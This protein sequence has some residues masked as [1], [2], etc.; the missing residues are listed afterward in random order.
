MNRIIRVDRL[1]TRENRGPRKLK[2]NVFDDDR[3][4]EKVI[5]W[6]ASIIYLKQMKRIMTDRFR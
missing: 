3:I 6:T 1:L 5:K 2:K 4:N